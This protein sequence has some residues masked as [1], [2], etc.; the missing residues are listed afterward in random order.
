[1]MTLQE[2]M[3]A[4]HSVR[5]FTDQ[6]VEAAAL[7]AV[8]A[9][10]AEHNAA[11]PGLRMC[12]VTD[13]P[14]A[15]SGRLARYGKF[16]GVRN[17]LALVARKGMDEQVGYHGE[18]IVLLLQQLGLNSCWVGLTY[19]RTAGAFDVNAG[20][21]LYALIAFGYGTT[22]GVQHRNKPAEKVARYVGGPAP[23]WF[24]EGVR[25]A[26]LAPTAM[27]QQKWRLRGEGETVTARA[28]IG[29]YTKVDLGIVKCHFD[30]SSG[31]RGS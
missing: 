21:K 4:R 24:T 25:A 27:N 5:S 29:F 14:H 26:L 2:A 22:Q 30:I 8:R 13:E 10:V 19:R 17:Y 15:F 16:S 11:V 20:E 28:G 12:L 31:F 7:E 23:Q 3:E 9:A 18:H 6:P 1:M